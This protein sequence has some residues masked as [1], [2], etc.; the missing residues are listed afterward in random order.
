MQISIGSKTLLLFATLAAVAALV[1]AS[2]AQAALPIQH[3]KTESGANVYFVEN[4]DLPMID[5][6]VDVPAGSSF[7]VPGQSGLASLTQYMLRLGAEGLSDDEI[8]KRLADVGAQLT[9]RFDH[10][11]AGLSLRTLSSAREREQ[12]LDVFARVLQSPQFPQ[13]VLEREKARVI[14]A[15]REANT[16]PESIAEHSFFAMLYG[17]HP[18]ALRTSGEVET[19]TDLKRENLQQFYADHYSSVNA[20]VA[21]IG[22]I[23]RTDAD[24]IAERV[25][26]KL[27]RAGVPATAIPDVQ[28]LQAAKVE[29]IPHPASQSHI[30]LGAVGIPRNH[31]DYFPLFVGNYVLGGGGFVS[32]FIEEVR[33]KRGLAYSVY[34]Y[35]MPLKEA[36]PFQIGLQTKK[37]QADDA[38]LVVRKTLREFLAGGPTAAELKAARQN[39][40]GGFPLR[41]DSNKKIHEYLAVIGFYKLPL[42]YLDTFTKNVEKVT[43]ADI[44]QV[45]SRHVDPDRMVTTVV[46]AAEKQAQAK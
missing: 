7:D 44:K 35:F 31:P 27:P 22:D 29:N 2:A 28:E 39:I 23:S 37:E 25:T 15:L 14:G 11:R 46:G 32:R 4:R 34:S 43:A 26:G 30:L 20:I 6:S 24:A 33:Q 42:D 16:K 8:S 12:A 45:F 3:W 5:V 17:D 41:I 40:I 19:V 18:Y 36:G 10:D 38:L 1:F 9:G 21:I 13:D